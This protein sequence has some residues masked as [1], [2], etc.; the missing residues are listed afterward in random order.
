MST[1]KGSE[2]NLYQELSDKHGEM[3]GG[4]KLAHVLG[5]AS[6]AAL[7]KALER[8]TLKL[9]VFHVS[10]RSGRF[11]LTIDVAHWLI[12]C[13]EQAKFNLPREVPVQLRNKKQIT[14]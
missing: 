2:E 14:S 7:C 9:S 13:R 4:A 10:G 5:Y 11:A 12:N 8:D 1:N 3:I 6:C